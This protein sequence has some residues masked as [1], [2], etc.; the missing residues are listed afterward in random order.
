M[1][2]KTCGKCK[3]FV[4]N[5]DGTCRSNEGTENANNDCCSFFEQK[6]ITNGDRIRQMRDNALAT[7][8]EELAFRFSSR[9]EF[10]AW[11][12]A[13]AESEGNNG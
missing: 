11:L 4:L 5:S 1:K 7:C 9:R 3:W 10:V 6:V 13:P 8:I 12:N 2:N